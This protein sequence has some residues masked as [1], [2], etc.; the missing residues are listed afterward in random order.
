MKWFKKYKTFDEVSP[1]FLQVKEVES[2]HRSYV[3]YVGRVKVFSDWLR[4]HG[5]SKVPLYKITSSNII[6][7]FT[8]LAKKGLDRTTCDK[9]KIEIRA[10]FKFAK[11]IGELEEVPFDIVPLPQKGKDCS[12]Q[13]ISDPQKLYALL[14]DIRENDLQLYVA[15]MTE[16]GC[17]VRPGRELRYLKGYNFDLI[18]GLLHVESKYAKNGKSRI[19]TIPDWLIEILKN[20]G[21]DRPE[22]Q[23]LYLFGNKHTF[24]DKVLSI[25][26]I[27][28]RFNPFRDKHGL[29]K[30]VKF[31][32]FKHTAVSKAVHDKLMSI[33]QIKD[34]CGHSNIAATQH[35]IHKIAQEVDLDIKNNF[36]SPN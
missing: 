9:Y 31:Y 25:N 19:V 15:C 10:V 1:L 27:R 30:E 8:S 2:K 26:M 6:D 13:V 14:S 16:Y 36:P 28:Y 33:E 35:Y 3:S 21:V 4:E 29:S 11:K 12:A 24:G 20:Y 32:S 34:Q 18:K 17:F 5:L 7:F 22:N 23:D